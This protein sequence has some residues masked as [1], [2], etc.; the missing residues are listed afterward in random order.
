M[1]LTKSF[2]GIQKRYVPRYYCLT[3]SLQMNSVQ[4][5]SHITWF[6]SAFIAW[7]NV[8]VMIL[9]P[10]QF[11][12]HPW[13]HTLHKN[14]CRYACMSACMIIEDWIYLPTPMHVCMHDHASWDMILH[15][16]IL[17]FPFVLPKKYSIVIICGA[18]PFATM[19]RF[20]FKFSVKILVQNNLHCSRNIISLIS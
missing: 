5:F 15:A 7:I 10:R 19:L 17:L 11:H 4:I 2:M 12:W 20:Y 13:M 1:P 9:R 6:I 14:A 18:Q 16:E 3:K 8:P